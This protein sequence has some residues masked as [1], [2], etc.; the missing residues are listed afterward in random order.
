MDLPASMVRP[1]DRRSDGFGSSGVRVRVLSLGVAAALAPSLLV[2]SACYLAA[3]A[4][5][6]E[7]TDRQLVT[8]VDAAVHDVDAWLGERRQD[9]GIFASSFVVSQDL[10]HPSSAGAPPADRIGAYLKQVQERSSLYQTLSVLDDTGRTVAR[11]GAAE[12]PPAAGGEARIVWLGGREGPALYLE[13]PIRSAGEAKV[14][15]LQAIAALGSLWQ[16]LGPRPATDSGTLRLA[17]PTARV[18]LSSSGVPLWENGAP[19]GL[20][21]CRSSAPVVARY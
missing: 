2:G 6:L 12:V 18:S 7:K 11:A 3:Q 14:G 16:R 10:S 20:D 1:T 9:V 5:L 13:A 4:I 15:T 17:T 21:R 19:Q 8:A